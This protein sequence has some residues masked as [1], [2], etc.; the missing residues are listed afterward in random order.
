MNHVV[1]ATKYRKRTIQ[2]DMQER[3][4]EYKSER[5]SQNKDVSGRIHRLP[6][7]PRH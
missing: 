4:Y 2:E 6:A 3:L 1:F 5:A 7:T